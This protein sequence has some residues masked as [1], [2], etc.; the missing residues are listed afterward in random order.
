ML[1]QSALVEGFFEEQLESY[2]GARGAPLF[3]HEFYE[4]DP[5]RG[6][7][8]GFMILMVRQTGAGWS[9][10]GYSTLPP[11]KWGAEHHEDFAWRMGRHAWLVMLSEDLPV[12]SNRVTLDPEVK[13]SSGLPAPKVH[14]RAHPQDKVLTHYSIA[15]GREV[16]EAAGATK[17]FDSGVYE[18]PPGYHLMGT[19]RM[20]DDP[21]T[22]V[23][24]KW[25]QTWDVPNL[26]VCDG[27]SFV[28][29]ASVNPT[30]TIAALAIR[31]A[32]Y[33]TTEGRSIVE[34]RATPV[35]A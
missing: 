3:S 8:N 15:R 5:S 33:L 22:S 17:I 23:T 7:V 6:F 26:F 11:V 16:M 32:D 18:Q 35:P 2:K 25:H 28:T 20:G 1:H 24:N 9:A 21:A 14:W 19:A 31:L 27:S 29:S 10:M 12:S 4:T 34:Q 13:D 30:P